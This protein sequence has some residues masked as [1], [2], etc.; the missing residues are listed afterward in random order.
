MNPFTFGI[1]IRALVFSLSVNPV[2]FICGLSS[3]ELYA[4]N[5]TQDAIVWNAT[6]FTD[7][8]SA[9]KENIPCRFV[10]KPKTK[11]VEWVQKQGANTTL[12]T[13]TEAQGEWTELKRNGSFTFLVSGGGASG[14]IAIQRDGKKIIL[15]LSLTSASGE[16][17]NEYT[18][19]D[20]YK[21][22]P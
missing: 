6:G 1:C 21:L 15:T 2:C 7:M 12:F 11:Q 8:L 19:S 4:Q 13:I 10:T 18:I 16:I 20:F 17:K 14:K 5:S 9:D 3:T 22:E